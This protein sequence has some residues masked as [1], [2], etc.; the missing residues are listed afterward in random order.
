MI[1][2]GSALASLASTPSFSLCA[3]LAVVLALLPAHSIGAAE[4]GGGACDQ[5]TWGVMLEVGTDGSRTALQMLLLESRIGFNG[6][7][8][9][10]VPR[11]SRFS[12]WKGPH[13]PHT[14]FH[15]LSV[16]RETLA[17]G[18]QYCSRPRVA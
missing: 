15:R 13:G 10:L 5:A 9:A 3:C 6:M 12:A 11:P 2:L 7:R 17:L 4:D 18:A 8:R 14:R 1:Q 16:F